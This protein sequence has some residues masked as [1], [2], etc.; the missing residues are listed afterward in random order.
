MFLL[1]AQPAADGQRFVGAVQLLTS[2]L[3]S[4]RVASKQAY[5]HN[6]LHLSI[7]LFMGMATYSSPGDRAYNQR[8]QKYACWTTGQARGGAN[9]SRAR[10]QGR[11]GS[12]NSQTGRFV[13]ATG[14]IPEAYWPSCMTFV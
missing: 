14:M 5:I 1:L 12:Q 7:R 3:H 2:L 8:P 4:V 11:R 10:G 9:P 13:S 6:S